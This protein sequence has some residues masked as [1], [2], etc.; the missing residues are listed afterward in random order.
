MLST[1]DTPRPN[2]KR[3]Y[4]QQLHD[5]TSACSKE[6]DITTRETE[7]QKCLLQRRLGTLFWM[8]VC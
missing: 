5:T 8:P 1:F 6:V 7:A 3:T 4:E 2:G